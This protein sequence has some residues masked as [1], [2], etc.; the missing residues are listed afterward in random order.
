[1][2][3]HLDACLVS[4]VRL[5][6][7]EPAGVRLFEREQVGRVRRR[8]GGCD[9]DRSGVLSEDGAD[10][11]ETDALVGALTRAQIGRREGDVSAIVTGASWR[12]P[13]DAR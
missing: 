5:D 13:G 10:E 1:M 6:E 9:D 11:G 2:R 4:D 8:A 7:L 3:T 12:T